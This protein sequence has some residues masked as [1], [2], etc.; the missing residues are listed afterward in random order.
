MLISG[1]P[2]EFI[3]SA[4][5]HRRHLPA[6]TKSDLIAKLLQENPERSDRATAKL[7]GVD[8]KTV[9]AVRRREEDVGNIPHVEKV[10]DTKGRRQPT[11]KSAK[12]PNPPRGIDAIGDS[13]QPIKRGL[14]AMG[15]SEATYQGIEPTPAETKGAAGRECE[16]FIVRAFETRNL[17]YFNGT[18]NKKAYEAAQKTAQAWAILCRQFGASHRRSPWALPLGAWGAIRQRCTPLLRARARALNNALTNSG[19]LGAIPGQQ[20]ISQRSLL[21]TGA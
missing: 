20:Q 8:R 6:E 16:A 3:T 13:N 9:G 4:N 7:V 11:T 10:I 12:P 1:D 19:K 2:V 21:V 14:L 15:R 5:V 17:T 18:P